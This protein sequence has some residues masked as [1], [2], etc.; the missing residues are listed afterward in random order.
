MDN[1]NNQQAISDDQELAKVLAGINQQAETP[2]PE[3]SAPQ[4]IQTPSPIVGA[5]PGS[6]SSVTDPLT[7]QPAQTPLEIPQPVV[8]PTPEKEAPVEST[9]TSEPAEETNNSNDNLGLDSSSLDGIKQDALSQ[10]RPLVDK[11]SVSPE[12]KFDTYLLLLRSTDD[13]SLIAP[14]YESARTITDEA[15]KAQALLDIIKEID[16]LTNPQS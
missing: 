10:L 2:A 14:A 7:D 16:Y 9:E 1:S 5:A 13:K 15:R 8:E 11:L 3:V 4:F 6:S 12:E